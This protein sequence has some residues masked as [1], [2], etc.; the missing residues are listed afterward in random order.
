MNDFEKSIEKAEIT[1]KKAEK[2]SDDLN[3]EQR[4]GLSKFYYTISLY[5]AGAISLSITFLS[6]LISNYHESLIDSCLFGIKN[7]YFLYFSWFWFIIA[8]LTGLLSRKYYAN[9]TAVSGTIFVGIE[10]LKMNDRMLLFWQSLFKGREGVISES[11]NMN[12]R[13]TEQNIQK[14][15]DRNNNNKKQMDKYFK[16]QNCLSFI[17][18]FSGVLGLIFLIIFSISVSQTM[19]RVEQNKSKEIIINFK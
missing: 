6:T 3:K 10:E 9:Y 13:N 14:I 2:R 7:I 18:E 1:L 19:I 12:Q 8:F 17:C 15:K 4:A 11:N 5:S 16:K